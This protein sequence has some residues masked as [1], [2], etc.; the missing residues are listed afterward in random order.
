MDRRNYENN[1]VR[2]WVIQ[3]CDIS[4]GSYFYFDRLIQLQGCD[5]ITVKNNKFHDNSADSPGSNEYN[6]P[7]IM[8]YDA[9]DTV[10]ENN[11]FYNLNRPGLHGDGAAVFWKDDPKNV[12]VRYN[13][14]YD[15]NKGVKG[16]GHYHG[17]NVEV[18]QNIITCG[19]GIDDIDNAT[20]EY[21]IYNNIFYN[22]NYSIFITRSPLEVKIYNNIFANPKINVL[23]SDQERE[24]PRVMSN[25]NCYTSDCTWNVHYSI[26]ANSLSQWQNYGTYN[27]DSNSIETDI[28][29]SNPSANNF[30]LQSNSPALNAGIDRQDYD[31]DGD[32][33]E[34]INMG[35]YITGCEVIGIKPEGYVCGQSQPAHE[36]DTNSN[37]CVDQTELTNYIPRWYAGT[38][39]MQNLMSA[40]AL[41]IDNIGC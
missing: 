30:I 12:T 39:T 5:H 23:I 18:Y 41:W 4:K 15:C 8:S 26:V 28:V 31:R 9:T 2:Y 7:A 13:Y 24:L 10:V 27:F 1:P 37:N 34:R 36:A 21:N 16:V 20:E 40:I 35:V 14:F 11:E 32:T 6:T 33:S 17:T 29:F 25:Y 19:I 3:N 38:V 22:N